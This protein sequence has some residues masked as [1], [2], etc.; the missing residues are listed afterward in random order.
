[1][2]VLN[3]GFSKRNKEQEKGKYA[4]E[5]TLNLLQKQI[6]EILKK[7]LYRRSLEIRNDVHVHV[8]TLM[9][10]FVFISLK[11][12]NIKNEIKNINVILFHF[13]AHKLTVKR[14]AKDFFFN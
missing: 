9:N 12:N 10:P 3:S 6:L 8:T 7:G 13:S 1:M 14:C 5:G 2:Y 4:R 11:F